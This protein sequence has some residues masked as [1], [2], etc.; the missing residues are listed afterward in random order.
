MLNRKIEELSVI[1]ENQDRIDKDEFDEVLKK[2]YPYRNSE[3]FKSRMKKIRR[4]FEI[5]RTN[6]TMQ[7]RGFV[8]EYGYAGDFEMIDKIYTL[9]TSKESRYKIWDEYFHSQPAPIAVRNRKR[10]FKRKLL[11]LNRTSTQN[12]LNLASGPCR[13]LVELFT[14]NEDINFNFDCVELDIRAIEYATN[15]LSDYG[16]KVK[17]I[18][19]NIFRYQ[20]DS[21]YDIIWSAGL[22][23][24][25][26][27]AT[28][29][30]IL[31]RLL[32][33]N[34]KSK[35]IIGNFSDSNP[36]APYMEIIGEWFL[37]HRS[38]KK[39]IEIAVKA[40]ADPQNVTVESEPEK[41]NLFL[42]IN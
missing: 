17:F 41:V 21:N 22:F 28:F 39:L 25:F 4:K 16:K 38:S 40:G 10:Y 35:I 33:S 37:N 13:D 34:P 32:K 2:L 14:E 27:D 8:K 7:G 6:C 1:L 5:I 26:N 42:N 30:R 36:T 29:E 9:H 19:K 3:E 12:V 11:S 18:N 31:R 20:P 23:D 15:L 24:Y